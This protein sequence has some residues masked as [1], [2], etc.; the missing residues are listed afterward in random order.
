DRVVISFFS[1]WIDGARGP[2]HFGSDLGG[3]ADGTLCDMGVYPA[4]AL[5]KLPES[6]S[7]EDGACLPC[8]GVTAWNCV[9]EAGQAKVGETVLALGTGGVSIFAVQIAKAIG[10]HSVITSSS[11][12]KLARAQTIGA[13]AGVNYKTTAD[14]PKA[15]MDAT[16]GKGAN[17]IVETAGPGNLEK[18]F[19]S[20]AFGG[21]ISLVGGFEQAKA[22]IN[23]IP[24]IG[25]GLTLRGVAVG[26]RKMMEDLLATLVKSNQK[27]VIDKTI[28]FKD[29]PSAYTLM[30]SGQHVGKIVIKH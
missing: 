5:V 22:P 8:A 16:G 17:V 15:V 3:G 20:A 24:M 27:P 29:A 2:Q 23:T 19:A 12:D 30:K 7:F 13:T 4:D 21:R 28:D 11:D 26:S 9:V 10:C 18:S 25:K 6:W 14:W 1:T